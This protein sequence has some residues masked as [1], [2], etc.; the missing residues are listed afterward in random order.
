MKPS[1]PSTGFHCTQPFIITHPSSWY[2]WNTV[3]KDVKS[4]VIHPSILISQIFRWEGVTVIC[5]CCCVVVLRLTFTSNWQLPFLNQR[6]EKVCGQTEYR[7]QDLWLSSQVPYRLRYVAGGNSDNLGV[8]FHISQWKTMLWPLIRTILLSQ[9]YWG[10]TIYVSTEKNGII[11]KL[12]LSPI[13]NLS[14]PLERKV[15]SLLLFWFSY[16]WVAHW[17]LVSLFEWL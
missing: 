3:E 1:Q 14:T 4:Q 10:V 12:S 6:K 15:N 9:F 16:Q 7:T 17:N 2:D 11:P 13:L 8:I 5:C